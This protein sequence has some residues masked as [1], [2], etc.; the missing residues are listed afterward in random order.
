MLR[1]VLRRVWRRVGDL[2]SVLEMG[3]RLRARSVAL[4]ASWLGGSRNGCWLLRL[5]LL[6]GGLLRRHLGLRSMGHGRLDGGGLMML[7]VLG[8]LRVLG[9]MLLLV[10]LLMLTMLLRR[11]LLLALGGIGAKVHGRLVAT[12]QLGLLLLGIVVRAGIPGGLVSKRGLL[13]L[14]RLQLLLLLLMRRK[15]VLWQGR[16]RRRGLT[17][18]LSM[19]VIRDPLLLLLL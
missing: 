17:P 12:S 7:L 14:L 9:L 4:T 6:L 1:L 15:M 3:G 19:N 10:M 8:M 16:H 18:C 13:L 11:R 5:L 2:G